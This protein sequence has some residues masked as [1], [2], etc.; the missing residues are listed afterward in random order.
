MDKAGSG[1]SLHPSLLLGQHEPEVFT[2]LDA[3]GPETKL[4]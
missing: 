3:L 4:C 1:A 2:Q